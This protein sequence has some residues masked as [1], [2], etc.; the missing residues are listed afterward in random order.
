MEHKQPATTIYTDNSTTTGFANKNMEMKRS[1]SWDINLHWLQDRE[2]R[3][4]FKV[5]WKKGADNAVDYFTKHHTINHHK[6]SQP[7]YVRDTINCLRS[8]LTTI[9]EQ[10][11]HKTSRVC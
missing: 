4:Q 1:K 11:T 3:K 10:D 7:K 2:N 8:Q 5:L 9:C 6:V